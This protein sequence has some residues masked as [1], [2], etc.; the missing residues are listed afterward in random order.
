MLRILYRPTQDRLAIADGSFLES[1][2]AMVDYAQSRPTIE[3]V[4]TIAN[5]GVYTMIRRL[6]SEGKFD[7]TKV[8][9]EP[10]D[11]NEVVMNRYSAMTNGELLWPYLY[12]DEAYCVI[13]KHSSAKRRAEKEAARAI[14]SEAENHP[15]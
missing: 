4:F 12:E 1:A 11:C 15:V 8:I 13:L 6:C 2:A 9:L 5:I 3:T 10:P 14:Y 7:P